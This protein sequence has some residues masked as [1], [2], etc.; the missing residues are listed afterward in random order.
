MNK[1][2][3]LRKHLSLKVDISN[4]D[5]DKYIGLT[6][7]IHLKKGEFFLREGKIAKYQAFL[8][9][10][11]MTT[12]TIDKKGEK[13]VLQIA[14]EGHWITDL[15]SYLSREPAI[16][17]IEALDDTELLLISK[18]NFDRACSEIP[19]FERFF[20]LLIQNGLIHQQRRISN[21]YSESAEERYLK[22]I[23]EKP[24]VVQSV[25]QHLL[26]SFLGIKPQS[27][28]RIRK[29]IADNSK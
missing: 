5:F 19:V 14:I 22:L 24:E 6:K 23:K 9:N 21:I 25:P 4:A 8:L 27:L 17:T 29:Q 28:S 10:G 7:R 11:V 15:Y 1:L 18:D 3:I 2:E 26:A 12:Y 20:R 13:H 16:Y